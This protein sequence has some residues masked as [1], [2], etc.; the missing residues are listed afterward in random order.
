MHQLERD[1]IPPGGLTKYRHGAQRWGVDG[2]SATERQ[3]IWDAL[4][5]MQGERCA[6]C[7]GRLSRGKRHIEHFRQRDRYSEGTFEWANLFG[8]CNREESCGKH[9]DGCGAYAHQDLIK[10][11]VEDP[12]H[13][14][15]FLPTGAVSVRTALTP[16]E[17]ERA[18]ETIRIFNLNGVLEQIRKFE[19]MGYTQTALQFAE[20]STVFP[21]EEWLPLLQEEVRITAHLPYA[22][23]IKHV[24]TRQS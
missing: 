21:E 16:T 8:S 2:P 23:A 6:Y 10:P 3:A 7:E 13:F 24:L 22:T 1:P 5:A 11:D 20:W 17:T 12:E 14:L 19:V 9:K 18:I 4:D 15:V